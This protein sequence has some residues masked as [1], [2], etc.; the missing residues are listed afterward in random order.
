[1]NE[2]KIDRRLQ[3]RSEHEEIAKKC[4]YFWSPCPL[5]G[6]PFGGHEWTT[7]SNVDYCRGRSTGVC[8]N[9]TEEAKKINK[10]NAHWIEKLEFLNSEDEAEHDRLI[11]E[12]IRK[13]RE[14]LSG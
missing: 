8:D 3:T 11:E 2:Q 10:V 7:G 6:E 14:A 9:C 5:C 13:G 12:A 4:G 1:M